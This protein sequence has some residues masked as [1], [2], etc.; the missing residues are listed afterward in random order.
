MSSQK[1]LDKSKERGA[2]V[3]GATGSSPVPVSAGFLFSVVEGR[4]SEENLR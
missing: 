1:S 3:V 4:D 2:V